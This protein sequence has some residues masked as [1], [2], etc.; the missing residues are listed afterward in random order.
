MGDRSNYERAAREWD[1]NHIIHPWD[2]FSSP[3][4]DARSFVT[5][6]TGVH[7]YADDGRKIIDGPGGMWCVQIGYDR[8][9]MA[10]AMASQIQASQPQP[11]LAR[12]KVW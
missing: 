1:A 8:P 5:H 3:D 4:P 9:E 10:E 6:A 7:I 11:R 12:S 2:D